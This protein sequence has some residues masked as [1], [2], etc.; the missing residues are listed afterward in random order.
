MVQA[1]RSVQFSNHESADKHQRLRA[2]AH[3]TGRGWHCELAF[4][5]VW[6]SW[7]PAF[8][9]RY[10]CAYVHVCVCACLCVQCVC[11]SV[12]LHLRPTTNYLRSRLLQGG[13]APSASTAKLHTV[14]TSV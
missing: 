11:V 12:S 10:G 14:A 1:R 4:V 2:A 3:C 6:W 7:I 8:V 9:S 5:S 13:S